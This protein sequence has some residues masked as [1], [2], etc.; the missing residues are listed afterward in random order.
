MQNNSSLI[1]NISDKNLPTNLTTNYHP[2]HRWYNFIAGFSPEFVSQC[3]QESA[4]K[5]DEVI[6]DPFAGL[7]TTLVQSNLEGMNAIGF[8]VHPFFY[9][10]SC[11]KISPPNEEQLNDI[12]LRCQ[13]IQPY[14]EDLINI[15]SPDALTFLLKLIPE[16]YLRCLASALSIEDQLSLEQRPAYRLIISR[17]LELASSSQTDGIYKAPTTQKESIPYQ[18]ALKKVCDEIRSDIKLIRHNLTGKS[19]LYPITAESMLPIGDES[20]SLCITSPPYLNNFDFAEMTRMEL[21]FWRY[22]NS[23]NEI[24]QKVRRKLIV[25]TTTAPTDLKRNQ[26]Q[27]KKTLSEDFQSY[28]L[29]LFEE[30][31][32]K[33]KERSGKKDYYLLLYPYFAQM[34]SV[35]RELNRILKPK[36]SLHLVIADSALYGVHI[37]TEKLLS[38]LMLENGFNIV[39]IRTLRTRGERWVLEKR[40][41]AKNPLGEFHIHAI[42]SEKV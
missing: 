29:P 39:R 32:Q 7:S 23:W 1:G 41:G 8:E 27:F 34:Q 21:Y 4:L 19:H 25:N 12:E 3:I 22:A 2:I 28:I 17:V 14:I 26:Q 24:T 40:Q 37:E 6:I 9:E 36:S 11:A 13:S 16:P 42:R 35:F 20:C 38:Q 30:L 33:K 5:Q 18:V 15:W 31:Q 10:I